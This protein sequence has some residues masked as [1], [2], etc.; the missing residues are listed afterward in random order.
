MEIFFFFLF[1]LLL[2]RRC[3]WTL[4]ISHRRRHEPL[5]SLG[6]APYGGGSGADLG[7]KAPDLWQ[8]STRESLPRRARASRPAPLQ[9]PT[10]RNNPP[11]SA[12]GLFFLGNIISKF[13]NHPCSSPAAATTITID[14]RPATTAAAST[15]IPHHLLRTRPLGP[16]PLYVTIRLHQPVSPRRSFFPLCLS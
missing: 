13:A 7:V 1:W 3:C 9:Q 16:L 15:K 10:S 11:G 2:L 6:L 14:E 8:P 12:R 5:W 4:G